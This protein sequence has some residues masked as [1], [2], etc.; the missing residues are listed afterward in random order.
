MKAIFAG[1]AAVLLLSLSG[2]TFAADAP[3]KGGAAAV[4]APADSAKSEPP[5]PARRRV[6]RTADARKCLELQDNRL[7]ARCAHPYL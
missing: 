3:E 7:V 5:A 6:S 4:T 1:F 2:P